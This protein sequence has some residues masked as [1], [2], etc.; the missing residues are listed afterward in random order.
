MSWV[1]EPCRLPIDDSIDQCP[2]CGQRV[3]RTLR[4]SLLRTR[5]R[6]TL[7]RIV[8]FVLIV[9]VSMLAYREWNFQ[10]K[11]DRIQVGM[12]IGDA[13]QLMG[14]NNTERSEWKSRLS[15]ILTGIRFEYR[16]WDP[17][18]TFGG[19]EY[20]SDFSRVI[21]RFRNGIVTEVEYVPYRE[22]PPTKFSRV[23]VNYGASRLADPPEEAPAPRAVGVNP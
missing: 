11:V 19:K 18:H 17:E 6:I 13:L 12:K 4:N 8:I 9:T 10:S 14:D 21:V 3:Q 2:T 20:R 15:G 7:A 23:S 1:C 22:S 5:P 16:D